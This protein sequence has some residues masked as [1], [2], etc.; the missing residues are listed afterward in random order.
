MN[1]AST[2]VLVLTGADDPTADAVV[3]ELKH[4]SAR[5]VRMDTGDFPSALRLAARNDAEGW[6]GCLVGEHAKVHLAEVNS[7]YYRRPTRFRMPDGLS[8]GDAAFAAAEA[9]LGLG[10][11][12]A[13]LDA[14]WVNNPMKVAVAEYKP[15]QLEVA[16]GAGL[17]V[18]RT[19]VTNHLEAATEFA[20]DVGPVVCKTFSSLMLADADGMR[21]T[22]TTHVDPAGIDGAQFA[23][24]T[25]LL[26]ERVPKDYEARVTMV[27]RQPLG[28][29]IR[30]DSEQGRLDWRTDYPQLRYEPIEVPDDV[31]KGMVAYLDALGLSYGAFDF[32]ITPQGEWIMFECNP[33]GQWLW[34]QQETGAPIA[35]ALADLLTEEAAA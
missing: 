23:A 19:L 13:C 11:V 18:P 22:F 14:L 12:L 8:D 31:T 5:V 34:L 29:A 30:T 32:A 4:R 25:H 20:E 24:T 9:R 6:S 7:V 17:A 27:G 16:A 26:Q 35:A 21:M 10:G 15:L 2:T 3:T 33:A 28:V 1:A